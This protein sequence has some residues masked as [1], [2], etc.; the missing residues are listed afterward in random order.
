MQI[1]TQLGRNIIRKYVF[2]WLLMIVSSLPPPLTV[3]NFFIIQGVT[4]GMC[5]TSGVCSL[6]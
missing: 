3:D 6:C 5:E 1:A 4:G 2:I